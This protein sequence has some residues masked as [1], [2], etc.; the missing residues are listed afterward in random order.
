MMSCL[1]TLADRLLHSYYRW[2]SVALVPDYLRHSH[3]PWR[4]FVAVMLLF[5][6]GVVLAEPLPVVIAQKAIT[7]DF[8]Q[9]TAIAIDAQ[10]RMYVVDGGKNRIVVLSPEGNVL[11]RFSGTP[12][13]YLPMDISLDNERIAVADSGNKRIVL[14]DLK[15]NVLKEIHPEFIKQPKREY[16]DPRPVAVF[17]QDNVVYWSDQSN[18]QICYLPLEV[19]EGTNA[20]CFGQRDETEG[21]F[22][23][24]FQISSDK[25]GYLHI[26]DVLN[27]RVQ[28][29][30]KKGQLFSQI[31]RFGVNADELYRP[32]GI[33]I[34]QTDTV[35]I[36]DN[37]F[38][39][40]SLFKSGKFLGKLQDNHGKVLKFNS[41][42]GLYWH[43]D[44]L[45]VV[46]T[47][48]HSVFRLH[49]KTQDVP[50]Q[51]EKAPH[52]VEI[53]QKNCVTCHLDWADEPA[54]GA[55]PPK[56]DIMAVASSKMCYSCHN[57]VMMDSRMLIN[58]G[59]QH[60]SV[61]DKEKDKITRKHM[62]ERKDKMPKLFPL[63]A[64]KEMRCTSCHTPHNS[65]DKHET[66]HREN[67]NAWLRVTAHDGDLCERCHESKQKNARELDPKK[68]GLNHPL[69]ITFDKASQKD[70]PGFVKEEKLVKGLPEELKKLS[71]TLDSRQRLICQSC[72]Q[73]HGGKDNELLVITK[74]HGDLCIQC[75]D[76]KNS[77]DKKDAHRKGIHPVNE[78]LEKP[79]K[80]KDEKITHVTC[81]SCHKVHTGS[82]G[83]ALLPN[84]AK[85]ADAICGD[86]HQRQNA[87]DKKDAH[88]KG[89][90]PVNFT[91]KEPVEF[92]KEKIRDIRCSTCHALHEGSPDSAA[93]V[94]LPNGMKKV[95]EFCVDCHQRQN[96]KDKEDARH[97][98]V[99]PVNFKLDE[100]ITFGKE[101]IHNITCTT[102]HSVHD[103]GSPGT[104]ALVNKV[105]AT[106]DI[107][108][109][110]HKRQHAGDKDEAR[111]KGLHPV[112]GKLDDV[113]K[114][115][116][117]DVQKLGCLSCHSVHQ[118]VKETPALAEPFK[119]G[120]LCEHCHAQKQA[121][122]GSDHDLRI[123]AKTRKNHYEQ[124]PLESGVCGT[125][126]S[127]HQHK[128][129]ENETVKKLHLDAV[130]PVGNLLS[131]ISVDNGKPVKRD[132]ITFKEDQL[133]LNC[134]QKDGISNKKI[135]NHFGHPS[136]DMI[137]RSDKT[138]MPL[139]DTHEKVQEFGAIA[140]I[141][142]HDP[143]AWKAME[144]KEKSVLSTN[145]SNIEGTM[146]NSFLRHK[147]VKGTFCVE[148]HGLET[149]PKYKY[150]HDG[151]LVRDIGVDYLK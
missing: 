144:K 15:G 50:E 103:G 42:T 126:H 17:L 20:E 88:S 59:S 139:L 97:K 114:I 45:Y 121:V 1:K 51:A 106:E 26:V 80:R 52:R 10:Q 127:M 57:G 72:H 36:A 3:H 46:D 137:L 124:L 87:N 135:I 35:Y 120:E 147:D 105:K 29:F 16:A 33:A 117:L 134:H 40:I 71:A 119:N 95:D 110:C 141:T 62:D 6:G 38:G 89:V 108:V 67:K 31:S 130:L 92:R 113:V 145:T 76:T 55:P 74:E 128:G 53:S 102:C 98:G 85:N 94:K 109:D 61:D 60:P 81:D 37:Y 116:K 86:C 49:L 70:A 100:P 27:A 146:L 133:C 68:R 32:N 82:I 151:K 96:A 69:A 8:E 125:C 14:F 132:V 111:S 79:I 56:Q 123:S 48:E 11:S 7:A 131:T 83:T 112:K 64:D 43:D 66:L 73:V 78:K 4:S 39:T 99:H 77:N 75:H 149:L 115:N 19:E 30:N 148:C 140:C 22:Q 91:L 136:K 47:P 138:I 122:V 12:S 44:Q 41:P 118:G 129:A 143:H 18:H 58:H 2:Q 5:F 23:Y 9:P 24:P 28:V 54:T 93:L 65:D 34:D 13:L 25:A 104:A 142:C 150:F 21:N 101:K 63:T 107:C 84:D 90:H